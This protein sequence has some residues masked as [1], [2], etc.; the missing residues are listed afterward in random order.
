M[1][2]IIQQKL[3]EIEKEYRI[4]ILYSCESGSRM[5]FPFTGQ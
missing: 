2:T 3:I 5:G 1:K 4:K